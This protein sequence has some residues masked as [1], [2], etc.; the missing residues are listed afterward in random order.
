MT[1][2][3]AS[4]GLVR[5]RE[6]AAGSLAVIDSISLVEPQLPRMLRFRARAR[7]M[8]ATERPAKRRF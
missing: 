6:I 7:S 1:S 2:K 3:V 5:K 4:T 8:K